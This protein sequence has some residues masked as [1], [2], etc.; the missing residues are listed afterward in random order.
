MWIPYFQLLR[1]GALVIGIAVAGTTAHYWWTGFKIGLV[2]KANHE[3][4]LKVH[5]NE[6]DSLHAQLKNQ[7]NAYLQ[8]K[9]EAERLQERARLHRET[10]RTLI[11]NENTDVLQCL[12]LRISTDYIRMRD[13]KS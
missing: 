3:T 5:Q 4:I 1:I 12:D 10:I 9:K 11:E 6:I 13:E 8:A 7:E 2:N